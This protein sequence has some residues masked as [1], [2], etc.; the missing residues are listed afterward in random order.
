M[1]FN[2]GLSL[3]DRKFEAALKLLSQEIQLLKREGINQA[4]LDQAKATLKGGLQLS[5]ESTS[6][7]M[8]YMARQ[9]MRRPNESPYTPAKTL[10]LI[11]QI[12]LS[13]VND[14]IDEVFDMKT[15]A[16]A[17]IQ[18]KGPKL[19]VSKWLKF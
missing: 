2:I 4:E 19:S 16:S 6:S 5:L 9:V 14:L 11:D 13:E 7:R 15:W 8:N 1:S 10:K 3:E 18:P 12:K 17:L